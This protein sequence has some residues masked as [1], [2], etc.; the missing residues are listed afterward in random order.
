MRNRD[1]RIVG[2]TCRAGRAVLG[3]AAMAADLVASGRSILFMVRV[4]PG[5]LRLGPSCC[6]LSTT[7]GQAMLLLRPC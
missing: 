5:N 6:S 4:F 7:G 2:L 1:N 3:S